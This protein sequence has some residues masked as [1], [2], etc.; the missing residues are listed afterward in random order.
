MRALLHVTPQKRHLSMQAFGQPAFEVGEIG[1]ER[2]LG[3]AGV[4]KA[5]F[6]RPAADAGG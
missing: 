5:Q 3:D 1:V 4:G 6:A 2:Q